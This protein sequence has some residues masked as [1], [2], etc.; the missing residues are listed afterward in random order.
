MRNSKNLGLYLA[1]VLFTLTVLFT[2]VVAA[3]QPT[4]GT[5]TPATPPAQVNTG[6]PAPQTDDR[7]R[8][9]P[10]DVLD[11]R[12]FNRPQLSRDAVRVDGRGMI[13][14]PLIEGEIQAACH[15]EAEL[16]DEIAN[17]YVKYYR[18]L[19]VDIFI[20][21]YQSEPVA[22]IGAVHTPSRFQ[23]QRRVRLLDLLTYANGPSEHAGQIIQVVHAAPS[24][25]C[26]KYASE[27]SEAG[28]ASN[29]VTYKLSDT[30][31]GEEKSNPI[32]QPGDIITIPDADQVYVVGNVVRP[33]AIPMKEPITV[34]R[35]IA[36]AGGTLH[37]TKSDRVRIIRQV[38]GSLAKSEIY[39]DLKAIDRHRAEDVA[40]QAND[41][42]DVPTSGGKA[43]LRSL[44]GTIAP[45]V[46]Q[47]PVRVIP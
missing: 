30:L 15:T 26:Q 6:P 38:P 8:I 27:N 33:S 13:R 4:T 37:D 7:Y 39:I 43:L 11:I 32:V 24:L 46:S 36:M 44:V 25:V 17:L 20:K 16:A 35:A 42:V 18:H 22:V 14:M 23:L 31:R 21:E 41:V 45:T 34:S 40:L 2:C 9:G 12:I 5:S 3:Q 1:G 19:H 28:A 29:L 47:L 10:L